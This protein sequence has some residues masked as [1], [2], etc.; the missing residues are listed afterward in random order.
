MTSISA[1]ET[2]MFA[3]AQTTRQKRFVVMPAYN[4]AQTIARTVADIPPGAV[5]EILVVDDCSRDQTSEVA[6]TR[7]HGHSS[8]RISV[9]AAIRKRATSTPSMPGPITS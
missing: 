9:T 2:Q 4:A 6:R 1:V 7:T 3:T 8:R 5:D